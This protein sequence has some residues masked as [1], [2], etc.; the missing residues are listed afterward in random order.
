MPFLKSIEIFVG[1]EAFAH[2][3]YLCFMSYNEKTILK[4]SR[5][6]GFSEEIKNLVQKCFVYARLSEALSSV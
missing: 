6:I 3:E 4:S 2:Y 1:N 5:T